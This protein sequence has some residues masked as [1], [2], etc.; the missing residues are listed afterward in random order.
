MMLN[1]LR[2]PRAFRLSNV[3]LNARHRPV[4][5]NVVDLPIVTGRNIA[6]TSVIF[7]ETMWKQ[8]PMT[9]MHAAIM[10]MSSSTIARV[11]NNVE[12]PGW[13]VSWM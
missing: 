12:L 11:L 6:I 8:E 1:S 5:V 4:G 9:V 2:S 13:R 3:W 7:L 10:L